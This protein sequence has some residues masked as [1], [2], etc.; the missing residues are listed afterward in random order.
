MGWTSKGLGF[1]SCQ[2]Q[3]IFL[4]SPSGHLGGPPSHQTQWVWG[5]AVGVRWLGCEC[6]CYCHQVLRLRVWNFTFITPYFM[7]WCF[8][9]HWPMTFEVPSYR[10]TTKIWLALALGWKLKLSLSTLVRNMSRGIRGKLY[11]FVTSAV[12][13]GEWSTPCPCH[14]SLEKNP[15]TH[16]TGGL[17]GSKAGLDG[18]GEEGQDDKQLLNTMPS[19]EVDKIFFPFLDIT[20]LNNFRL[21][22]AFGT[23]VTLSMTSLVYI[24]M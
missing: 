9:N 21:L 16:W 11:S 19:M 5:L 10:T 15:G 4:I 17:L 1:C 2:R 13:G 12:D 14:F 8:I 20:V 3:D 22:A 24:L 7:A 6:D 23:K 18:F